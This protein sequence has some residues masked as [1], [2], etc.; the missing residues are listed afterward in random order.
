VDEFI[1]FSLFGGAVATAVGFAVAWLNARSRADRFEAQLA[2]P[3]SPRADDDHLEARV[4]EL[5]TQL[6][7]LARS[8]DFL[9][10]LI[11]KKLEHLPAPVERPR[12]VTPH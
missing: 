4:T 10:R 9:H 7:E 8:Q 6:D 3:T 2:S 5:A 12:E 11:S 1:F